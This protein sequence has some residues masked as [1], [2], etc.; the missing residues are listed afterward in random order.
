MDA[1]TG[2]PTMPAGLSVIAAGGATPGESPA[3]LIL[4]GGGYERH[5][6]HEAEPVAEWLA[7]LGIHAFVLRYRVAPHRHPEP[8]RDRRYRQ[9][10][11]RRQRCCVER[12]LRQP[13]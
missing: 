2:S 9:S 3:M 12:A 1:L 6:G 8:L 11:R 7:S 5:A 13:R 10:S 4:P